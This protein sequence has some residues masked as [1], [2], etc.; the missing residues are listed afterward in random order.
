MELKVN[1]ANHP[2]DI[3]KNAQFLK[4]HFKGSSAAMFFLVLSIL[5]KAKMALGM[6]NESSTM[7]TPPQ[8]R[9]LKKSQKA[10]KLWPFFQKAISENCIFYYKGF[11]TER[12]WALFHFTT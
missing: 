12:R 11:I 3:I 6:P 9:I 1:Y 7:Q 10:K 8:K 5:E 2:G 4:A